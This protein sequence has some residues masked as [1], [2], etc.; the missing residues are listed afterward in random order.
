[1]LLSAAVEEEDCE[2]AKKNGEAADDINDS[3]G[4]RRRSRKDIR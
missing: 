4:I 2:P 3:L 1:M